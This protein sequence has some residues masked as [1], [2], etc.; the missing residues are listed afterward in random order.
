MTRV[1]RLAL[2]VLWFAAAC[3]ST[4][5]AV[6]ST[7]GTTTAITS[8]AATITTAAVTTSPPII[9]TSTTTVLVGGGHVDVPVAES[10]AGV[11]I[12]GTIDANEWAGAVVA[13]MDDGTEVRFLQSDGYVYVAITGTEIGAVNVVVAVGD[14]VRVL[15]SSA[16]LGSALYEWDGGAWVLTRDFAWCCRGVADAAARADLLAREG[17][18]ANIGYAGEPGH[19]EY[20][21]LIEDGSLVAISSVLR[22][23]TAAV[24]P[25]DL[26]EDAQ[27]PLY[28]EREEVESF[29]FDGWITLRTSS[30][31]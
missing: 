12:D 26:D 22:D 16:A 29:D 19:V 7:T 14:V 21:M 28:G 2:V 11:V 25:A 23:G 10:A 31:E 17:W 5:P 15:H 30:D 24:W 4:Q 9:S 8:A 1:I 13:A 27:R 6:T 18:Q 3:S 20:Q